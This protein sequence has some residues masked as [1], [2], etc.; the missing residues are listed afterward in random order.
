MG[1]V[2]TLILALLVPSI[3]LA[4]PF[5]D[6]RGNWWDLPMPPDRYFDR[7]YTGIIDI[8]PEPANEIAAFCTAAM[9]KAEGHACTF[10]A[11]TRCTIYVSQDLPKKF[12]KAVERHELAHCRGWPADHPQD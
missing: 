12:R 4:E 2:L 3:A 11:P 6:Q 10:V 7:P 5:K 1:K 9:G 8:V